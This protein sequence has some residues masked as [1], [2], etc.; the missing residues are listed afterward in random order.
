MKVNKVRHHT[1]VLENLKTVHKKKYIYIVAMII[2]VPA[3]RYSCQKVDAETKSD[4]CNI[5][6]KKVH[7]LHS[8]KNKIK[9]GSRLHICILIIRIND[10]SR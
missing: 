8:P 6:I 1:T 9:N 4:L 10:K 7:G 5:F 2:D 3:D